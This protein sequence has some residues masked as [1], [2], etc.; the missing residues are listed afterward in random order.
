MKNIETLINETQKNINDLTARLADYCE[1]SCYVCDA[2]S[3]IVDSDCP[4]YWSDLIKWFNEPGTEDYINEAVNE[5]RPDN[6]DIMKAIQWGWC[7]Q[8]EEKIYEEKDYGL[9]LSAWVL[10]RDFYKLSKIS[11]GQAEEIENIDFGEIDTFTQLKDKI[12]EIINKNED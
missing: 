11:E 3:E 8:A 7:K 12:E 10:L 2:I 4:I 1:S 9:L 6:F 5:Y